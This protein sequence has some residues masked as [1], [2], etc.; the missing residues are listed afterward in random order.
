MQIHGRFLVQQSAKLNPF[1]F[2]FAKI[3]ISYRRKNRHCSGRRAH[4]S[5]PLD[6]AR[7]RLTPAATRETPAQTTKKGRPP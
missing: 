4:A 2:F 1:R 6:P 5:K 7:I 3:F